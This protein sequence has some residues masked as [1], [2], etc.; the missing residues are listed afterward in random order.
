MP[1]ACPLFSPTKL[2]PLALSV[3]LA[4]GPSVALDTGSITPRR[5]PAGRHH[6]PG[7]GEHDAG[8][9]G[10]DAGKE[11]SLKTTAKDLSSVPNLT[12][13]THLLPTLLAPKNNNLPA[14]RRS[15]NTTFLEE[16]D[17]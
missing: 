6:I 15:R 5:N 17:E 14:N 11:V 10:S 8:W 1:V 16:F 2:R 3:L 13:D 12:A 9:V 4:C 7:V